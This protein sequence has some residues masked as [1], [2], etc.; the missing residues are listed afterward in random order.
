L[1]E[2]KA[3]ALRASAARGNPQDGLKSAAGEIN[4]A[5]KRLFPD[6]KL[7]SDARAFMKGV[8]L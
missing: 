7:G 1:L 4:N 5:A 6:R 3:D 2:A 8:R